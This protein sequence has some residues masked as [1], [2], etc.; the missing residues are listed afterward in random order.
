MFVYTGSKPAGAYGDGHRN[1][2]LHPPWPG[3]LILDVVY[4][5]I[6]SVEVLHRSPM[7]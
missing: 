1:V 5:N 7:C 4:D 3:Y 6:V 2:R